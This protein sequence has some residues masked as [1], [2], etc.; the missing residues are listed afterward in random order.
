[1]TRPIALDVSHLAHRLRYGAPS[2]IEKVD[3][4][5]AG[6]FCQGDRIVAGVQYGI[7]RPRLM[8]PARAK[9]LT[10]NV[11]EKWASDSALADDAR[12]WRI[13]RWLIGGDRDGHVFGD[14]RAQIAECG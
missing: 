1:M 11:R 10:G 7:G 4:A 9:A 14:H 13:R 2:G 5:Y 6:H 12:F 3:L 8:S